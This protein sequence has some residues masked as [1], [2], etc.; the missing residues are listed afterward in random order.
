MK[1]VKLDV[2][3]KFI[4]A[5]DLED[6]LISAFQTELSVLKND[7]ISVIMKPTKQSQDSFC[8]G[9]ELGNGTNE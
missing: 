5:R 1:K 2:T 3:E 7:E 9:K 4:G 6:I 8:S